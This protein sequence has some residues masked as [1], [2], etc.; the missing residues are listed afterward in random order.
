M[1]LCKDKEVEQLPDDITELRQ[2]KEVELLLL[3]H[4]ERSN[5]ELAEALEAE[6]DAQLREA[7]QENL[8]AIEKKQAKITEIDRWI[9]QIIVARA[10]V[11]RAATGE[12][13]PVVQEEFPDGLDL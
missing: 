7:M 5:G 3:H 8:Q 11:N 12:C 2:C 1:I 13:E 4:L 6:E 10:S 9:Q